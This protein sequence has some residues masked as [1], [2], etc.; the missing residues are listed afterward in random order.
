MSS[1]SLFLSS[2]Q[3]LDVFNVTP[4]AT[5]IHI[6]EDASV[7]MANDSMLTI[8]G[9]NRSIIG[10]PLG[11]ALPE[12]KGQ[13]FLEMFKKVW[14]E[15][16]I[17]SG[18]DTAADLIIDGA[19]K[20]FYFDF[21]YRAIKNDKGRTLCILHTAI[22]VTERVINQKQLRDAAEKEIALEREQALN[23]ELA[24][25]N[26]ELASSNEELNA[27]NEELHE[28]RENLSNLN[29]ELE[30]RVEDRVK[31]LSDSEERLL[32]AIDTANMGTWSINP[33]T[34]EITMS[35]FV[36]NILGIPLHQKPNL[37]L[38]M[39]A[40]LPEYHN[41]LTIALSNAI[42]NQEPSDS[43]YSVKNLQTGVVKWVKATGKVFKNKNG[44]PS[45]YSGLFMDI[46]ERK[47]DELRKNDFIGMV[48]HELKTP[49]TA[50]N[51]F[52]Q[53]LQLKARKSEDNFATI[54]LEKAYNQI[55]KMT[56]MI[57]GFLNV[58]RLESGKLLVDKRKFDLGELFKEVVED[59]GILQSSH[60]ITL[61]IDKSVEINAD[62]D[63][64]GNVI[65]NLLNNA[66]KYSP[67]G[68]NI[69]VH[70][71]TYNDTVECY[72]KDN[73]IGIKPEDIDKLFERYY[74]VESNHTIAGFG[75]GLYLSAEI[76]RRHK[77]K[78]WVESEVN[79]GSSFY[80]S[81]PIN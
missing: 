18:K 79:K 10:K 48:S 41:M 38:V 33:E 34:L 8:W 64:I 75:I 43:E 11:E 74:R 40:I 62:R 16:L 70:C 47:L 24:T 13:P 46:T 57:N 52:V 19:L 9:K 21:E 32:Q 80:F 3:L 22:D 54:A 30:N 55:K 81:L 45:E 27:T 26:E 4:T 77:G 73:G 37:E 12:L 36:K 68:G 71:R 49:L 5:A 1:D 60:T 65:S 69:D 14:N 35:D 51:G 29:R 53:V 42:E 56:V 31:D 15:G 39:K 25:I 59:A 66:I 6:G 78:I 2:E 58:S 67:G 50:L 7:Q 23:E 44:V 20:T 61:D 72:I 28:A 76:V 63:K 17:I